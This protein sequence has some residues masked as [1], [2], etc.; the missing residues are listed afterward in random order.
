MQFDK[1]LEFAKKVALEA[2]AMMLAG[3]SKVSVSVKSNLTPVTETDVAISKLVISEVQRNFPDHA[4]LDEEV[5][6]DLPNQDY[7][8]VCDP[9][10]GTI[11]FAYQI[12]TSVF[13]LALCVKGESVVAVVYDPY[14]KRLL[15]TQKNQKSFMNGKEISV[16]KMALQKGDFIYGLK[17]NGFDA[18][19]YFKKM[20]ELG[21]GVSF[22]E[23]IVYQAMLLSC[24][25]TKVMVMAAANP[26]D[27]AAA[28]LLI[29]NA[30]GKCTDEKGN[31]LTVFGDPK[32]FIATNG[33]V[34]EEILRIAQD[35]Y[36]Q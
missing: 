18:N 10:D 32:L 17:H 34:H 28:I 21:I 9:I 15:Y 25:L 23:S 20:S 11:P 6:H 33:T 22:V 5:Q 16:N 29:E 7:V 4:V 30:G 26:W 27:R 1:E 31:K 13:S 24:G 36:Q 2:G 14:M 8:W 19:L 3:F 35:C 12:P